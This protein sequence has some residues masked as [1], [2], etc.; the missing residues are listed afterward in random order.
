[1][2]YIL[3]T[4]LLSLEQC[5]QLA[6][7]NSS[8]LRQSELAT[9]QAEQQS[10]EAFTNYFPTI[11]AVGGAVSLKNY[12]FNQSIMGLPLQYIKN[13]TIAS[14]SATQPLFAG[15]QIVNGNKLARVAVEASK[16]KE[17]IT[18]RDVNLQVTQYYW[19]IICLQEKLR[20]IESAETLLA[21]LENDL[22]T[23]I[24][25]GL[26]LPND[27]L[28]VQ[29]RQNELISNKL[30]VTNGLE[31]YKLLLG[32][33]IAVD[34][35]EL[36]VPALIDAPYEVSRVEDCAEYKL[37]KI[38]AEAAKL[39]TN[40]A[41]G[42]N[43]PTLAV[44]AG[45]STHTLLDDRANNAAI[46]A[47]LTIPISSWWGGTHAI[48]RSQLA[49]QMAEEQLD[50]NTELL[51]IQLKNEQ[52]AVNEAYEEMLL[53]ERSIAQSVENLRLN[54]QYYDAGTVTMS[55][56]LQAQQQEQTAR[57]NYIE[58]IANYNLARAAYESRN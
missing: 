53:A 51:E 25:V 49:Q 30:K 26:R 13:G 34:D 7:D 48:K 50:N 22:Q 52:N 17:Q 20:T 47:T 14:V 44:G 33:L 40:I 8:I 3:L 11:Q 42:K 21:K 23:A 5:L 2:I 37:L 18:Q 56:L 43:L 46:Y 57:D 24:R 32:Q 41:I 10:K 9:E 1:M 15:G 58:A 4:I 29:L 54:Q 6:Q 45:L 12:V 28:Q 55:E 38:K 39:N 27:L 35:F 36:Q 16:L 31:V 19:Q